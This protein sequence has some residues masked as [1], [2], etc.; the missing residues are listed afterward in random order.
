LPPDD[1]TLACTA[2]HTLFA[3]PS[4]SVSSPYDNRSIMSVR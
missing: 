4:V 1:P 2:V 3:T